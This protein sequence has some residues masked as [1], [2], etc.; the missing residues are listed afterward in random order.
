MKIP[1]MDI[2][3]GVCLLAMEDSVYFNPFDPSNK[4]TRLYVI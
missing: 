3:L 4:T 2:Q 1:L